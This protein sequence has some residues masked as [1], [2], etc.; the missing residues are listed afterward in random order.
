M[1]VAVTTPTPSPEEAAPSPGSPQATSEQ[2]ELAAVLA[3]VVRVLDDIVDQAVGN[4]IADAFAR[5]ERSHAQDLS[6]LAEHFEAALERQDKRHQELLERLL[7]RQD[8]RLQH[9]LTTQTKAHAD[10]LR[11]ALLE[12][13]PTQ[14]TANEN[15]ALPAAI[16]ELQE[17]TRRGFGELRAALDRGNHVLT[18]LRT[19]CTSL[20]TTL[21]RLIPPAEPLTADHATRALRPHLPPTRPPHARRRSARTAPHDTPPRRPSR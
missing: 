14:S 18:T 4:A 7:E 10:D 17:T 13:H 5:L 9:L 15:T 6:A 3:S 20:T 12:V 2:A 1:P 11:A 19:E 16:E 21:S 8:A